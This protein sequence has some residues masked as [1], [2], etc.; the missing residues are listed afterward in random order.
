MHTKSSQGPEDLSGN[1]AEPSQDSESTGDSF[2]R[3]VFEAGPVPRMP[4]PG[5]RLGGQE[6]RR[7]EILEK[8]GE[9]GMGQVFR[10]RDEELQRE[11]A[12]KFLWPDTGLAEAARREAQVIARLDHENI[13][14]IF[15]VGEWRDS[16]EALP[17]PFLV[18]ECL[19]G[20]QLA[21]WLRRERPGPRRALEILDA[22]AAGLA[23]AHE[24]HIIHRD[25][26][27]ANVF[28]TR[29]G[30]VKLLDFGLAHLTA[31]SA[32]HA[33]TPLTAGTPDYMAPEQWRGA[34]Q[35]A[36][37]DVWSAGVV[38]YEMLTGSP[39][40][41]S[42][43]L[44]ELRARVLSDEP[45]PPV[46]ARCPEL[47]QDVERFLST[48]LAKDPARRFSSA[49]ELR[50]ELRELIA[51]L[52]L[53]Q[54]APRPAATQRRQVTL[55][56][57]G[58][59]G[60]VDP[61]TPLDAEDLGELEAAFHTCSSELL[62]QHG[63]AVTLYMH[64]E[65][66][67]CFGHL[68]AREDDAARAVRA[69]LHL[70]RSFQEALGRRM[71]NPPR[72]QLA[73]KVGIQTDLVALEVRAADARGGALTLPGEAPKVAAWLAH[74][75]GPGEVLLGDATS[76]LVRGAFEL[77][78]LGPRTFEG[79]SGRVGLD[80][81]RALRERS[82]EVRFA[83]TLA[84]GGLTPLVGRE[85]G[86]QRL[87]GLWERARRGRGAFILLRGEAGIGKS[88][89]IRELVER[90]T[91]EP[92]VLLQSQCWS[93]L[94]TQALDPVIQVLQ[95]LL[96]LT[97]EATPPQHL[98]ELEE[99]LGA[100]GLSREDVHMLGLLLSLPVPEDSPLRR[101]TPERRK[102]KT[103]AALT[104]LF[105]RVAQARPVLVTLEDLHWADSTQLEF[106]G[107][108][109]DRIASAR[110]LVVISTR[111]ELQV[112]WPRR[113]GFH[114]L[115]LERLSAESTAT[116]VKG[117]AR[118]R[119]LPEETLQQLVSRTDGVPLFIEELTR[120]VLARMPSG[121]TGGEGRPR[122]LPAT[123]RE[124]LLARLDMLSS[125]QKALIQLC[126]VLGRDFSHAL[127]AAVTDLD[128]ES[129]KR[130]LAELKEVG[131][132][133]ERT[134]T[135]EPSYLFRHALIQEAAYESLSRSPRRQYHQRIA[136][137]L[138]ERFP[139]T[140]W[141][142]P[143]VLAHHYTEAGESEPA[144]LAWAH[145]GQL[146]GQRSANVEAV[147]AFTRALKLLRGL[148]DAAQRT[149]E[150]LQL[151][152]ALGTALSQLQGFRSPE[153]E[154][155]F[156]RARELIFQ[157]NEA[158]PALALPYWVVFAYH[159]E[160]AEHRQ[161]QEL[162]GQLMEWG[163]RQR[164][165]EV[166]AQGCRM[167]AGGVF[168]RG[169]VRSAVK[170]LERA[171]A[172]EHLE[173]T[174]YPRVLA[175]TA[176]TL[177]YSVAGRFEQSRH[178]GLE[179]IALAERLGN[180]LA[181]TSA[182]TCMALACQL[183]GEDMDALGWA[184]KAIA[185]SGERS[186]WLWRTWSMLIRTWVLPE[187]I[188]PGESLALMRR[189][190][191]HRRERGTSAGVTYNFGLLA[192]LHLKLGQVE[193]GLESVREALAWGKATGERVYEA[194]LH[195][196]HGELLRAAGR[197]REARR[198][199]IS[200]LSLARRQGAAPFELRAAVSLG[201]LL[202]DEGRPDLACRLLKRTRYRFGASLDGPD[203]REV[204]ALLEE[205]TGSEWRDHP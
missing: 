147:S 70:A 67:A 3:Q 90:A 144:I 110:M 20:E 24:R 97:A 204:G 27:P 183:R 79:L 103:F 166:L 77:E 196:L 184:D 193:E 150:E 65:V 7:F 176:A 6:D 186:N 181:L 187:R 93:Q 168:M 54:E 157:E 42:S 201:R 134:G 100:L 33:S 101:I 89:L 78:A 2:L 85:R 113:D 48:A 115:V 98:Q 154:R 13:V 122:A 83:R 148:P 18:T 191:E 140:V 45:V 32:R 34:P 114:E 152:C 29:Q 164:N 19:E 53:E 136:Q 86:L 175:L 8:L 37:T 51:H 84:S 153:V 52:V 95:R 179:S 192:R 149:R 64:D 5:E 106:L 190:I 163:E 58:L 82:A 30:V 195:R 120:M 129:L 199:F 197:E 31:A 200:A 91:R 62:Q 169:R 170:Y 102:E 47:P 1:A 9:G 36:R 87:L 133:Q 180:P 28:L 61:D 182:L 105:L 171:E 130:A 73:V 11:V 146:A 75:A 14:R 66:I 17:V 142:T 162:A 92:A 46:R 137:V 177:I 23:H 172:L 174:A 135:G 10:A 202:R 69:G 50:E 99:R 131:L 158:E 165:R 80:V 26:K 118:G 112:D 141:S 108:L 40:Y 203:L 156:T 116:L 198:R 56:C 159:V 72:S 16:P 41:T 35:D 60:Q 128:E 12:L 21:S 49:R 68:Q 151:M 117:V 38:L 104:A 81:H 121:M 107:F 138:T 119:A 124:L 55:V 15:D 22:I 178:H 189:H 127:L 76:Q 94:S 88:R 125:R 59:T 43:T 4:I 155:T 205:L 143:E 139:E 185:L 126:A 123:L 145:A 161:L 44:E 63:G 160:R 39:P 194:E 188:E 173:E 111:P 109:L 25:L 57:C 74:Q 96:Q 132:L 167:M 71:P